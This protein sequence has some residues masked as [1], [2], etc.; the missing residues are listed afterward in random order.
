MKAEAFLLRGKSQAFVVIIC[1]FPLTEIPVDKLCE[2]PAL[3]WL[4]VRANPLDS[5]TLSALQSPH[6]FEVLTTQS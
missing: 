4:N 2:M 5:N 6:R 3:K 1:S